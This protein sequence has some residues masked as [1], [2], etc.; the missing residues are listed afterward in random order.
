MEFYCPEED[1][2]YEG[3]GDFVVVLPDESCVDVHNIATVFCP[4]CQ[5]VLVPKDEKKIPA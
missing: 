2:S 4:Y 1:C 5:S 3:G